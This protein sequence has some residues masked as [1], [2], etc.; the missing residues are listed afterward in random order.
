MTF[1]RIKKN[2]REEKDYYDYHTGNVDLSKGDVIDTSTTG[3]PY[4]DDYLTEKGREYLYGKDGSVGKIV[5]MSPTEYYEACADKIFE[6]AT[7]NKLKISRSRDTETL[8]F[9]REVL[10]KYKKKFP[11]PYLNYVDTAQEGLHRMMV[12]GDMF[13]WDH[14]VP[15]L[16]VDYLP[17]ERQARIKAV[18]DEQARKEIRKIASDALEYPYKNIEEFIDELNF[19]NEGSKPL[20]AKIDGDDLI[21]TRDSVSVEYDASRLR[22]RDPNEEEKEI[23]WD[24]LDYT[25][26]LG[27]DID[28]DNMSPDE[29]EKY[30]KNRQNS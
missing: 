8:D 23:N 26:I 10:T 25:D 18:E 14:K 28:I 29:F 15:V 27:D 30:L 19:N 12:I 21:I 2:V 17:E 6:N 9:L 20:T 3:V 5:M 22:L 4:Y 16:I 11:L 1:R 7:V 24:D 13:G